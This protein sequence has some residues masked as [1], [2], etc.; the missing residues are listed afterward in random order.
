MKP[1]RRETGVVVPMIKHNVDTDQVIPKQ[2]LKRIERTGYGPFLFNNWRYNQ[3]GSENPDFVLNREPFRHGGILVVGRNF[4]GGSS[5]QHAVWALDQFG[6]RVVIAPGFADIFRGN[7]DKEGLLTVELPEEAVMLLASRAE[8]ETGVEATVDLEAQ[9]VALG[10]LSYSFE[11]D[12]FL[13]Q[14]LLEGLDDIGLTLAH[15]EEITAFEANRPRWL[16]DLGRGPA[17]ASRPG[18][19]T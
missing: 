14:C 9:T 7:A 15:D 16:P 8:E 1:F 4:G 19:S 18:R 6:F 13:K 2:F 3:D 11:V 17:V 10:E 5:R 12:P